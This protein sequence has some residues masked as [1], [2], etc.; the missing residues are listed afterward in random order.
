MKVSKELL[1]K[2]NT[3]DTFLVISDYPE[4]HAGTEKNYGIAWHTKELLEPLAKNYG[5]KFVV[6]AEKGEHIKPELYARNRIL[7]LRIFDQKHPTLFPR[8]LKQLRT[9]YNIH[10]VHVHSE[11]SANGGIK[12]MVL[13]IPFLALIKLM[14]KTLTYYTHNV[15]L[16]INQI[17]EH[18]N[19]KK[20]S[21]AVKFLN[22]SM[23]TYYHLLDMLVSRFVVMDQTIQ[24]RLS[25]MVSA[26]KIVNLPFWIEAKKYRLSHTASKDKLGFKRND[27]LLV[28][29]GFITYYKGSDWLIDVVKKIRQEHQFAHIK[30]I[31]AGGEA[32]SLQHKSYY[33]EYYHKLLDAIKSDANIT[34]TG[35]VAEKDIGL[36]LTAA[37]LVVLPYRGL[38]GASGTLT[39]ILAF[40]RPFIMSKAMS[41]LLRS[42]DFQEAL[43]QSHLAMKDVTFNHSYP[44]FKSIITD[45]H[46]PH[47]VHA[48]NMLTKNMAVKRSF[49]YLLEKCYNEIHNDSVTFSSF[50]EYKYKPIG[51]A[52]PSSFSS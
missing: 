31:L 7:V 39:H 11:F 23:K 28:S 26:K 22:F 19:M 35:F 20:G 2:F 52:A 44:G 36:Y 43:K 46:D 51:K 30:L 45:A 29:F 24:K 14:G 47:F 38:I 21:F 18:M 41:E 15:V 48:L 42:N 25:T 3:P 10:K 6:L 27:F 37:D 9:F 49:N 13:L 1:S 32:Y 8:I 16:D 12:N 4:K 5:L 33:Q 17:A 40:K 34:I 50:P